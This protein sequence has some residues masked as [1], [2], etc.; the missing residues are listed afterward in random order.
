M[1]CDAGGVFRVERPL[2][3]R[4]HQTFENAISI[5]IMQQM[6]VIRQANVAT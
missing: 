2:S 3:S 5:V 1:P 4:T 6:F